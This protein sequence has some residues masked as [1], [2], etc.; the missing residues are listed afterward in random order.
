MS[1]VST[2]Q[3]SASAASAPLDAS[4]GQL[5]LQT[6]TF[7]PPHDRLSPQVR[8]FVDHLVTEAAS[9][10]ER[11]V[12]HLRK[13]R[14][15]LE[16]FLARQHSGVTSFEEALARESSLWQQ[17]V[18]KAV[19]DDK[20]V[21]V[22]HRQVLQLLP[23]LTR[24]HDIKV[25]KPGRPD[26]AVY[27]SSAY[28]REWLP[29]GNCIAEW[30]AAGT[31]QVQATEEDE[32]AASEPQQQTKK[33]K[34]RRTRKNRSKTESGESQQPAAKQPPN[35][36]AICNSDALFFPL[37]RGYRKF[38]GQ[39][40]DG[41]L[42]KRTGKEDEELS[43]FFTKPQAQSRW[44]VSTA[45]ENGEAGH[46]AVLKRGDGQFVFALGS[47][48]THLLAQTLEDVEQAREA[49]RANGSDPFLAAAPIA[50]AVLRMVLALEPDSRALLCEFLWQ[51][52]ATASFE[53][54]CPS[55]QHVQLLDY[56]AE[57]TPV[58]Y[59]L[60][61]PA[62]TPLEGAEICVN[63]VLPYELMRAL[64]VRTVAY[65]VAEF[66]P[67]AFR[68]AL[69]TS[70]RAYQHEGGVHLFLDADAAVIG[71][72]KHKS[73][74]YV[75]LRAIREKSK[76]FCRNLY[77]KKPP[78]GKQTAPTP[79]EVLASAKQA[80]DKRFRAI[81]AFLRI[82]EEVCEAY[83]TLGERF[84]EFLFEQRLFRG[85]AADKEEEE[86]V[87]QVARDVADLFP[88]VWRQ[89]LDHTGLSDAIA[90]R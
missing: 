21:R 11:K 89:F 3:T 33:G 76:A 42:K 81:P 51:T 70:K 27:Q 12:V 77:S 84:L 90:S 82:S 30:R 17:H 87:K 49:Q 2:R 50:T 58:F 13:G 15:Q 78:K 73:V 22:Q 52:R 23:G 67:E 74:W 48:N 24:A 85:A 37:I 18:A 44:V 38:T 41:E 72:Q 68:A 59:G 40:D 54:L 9:K 64:G 47:K 28:A 8:Q 45:K 35:S 10:D 88:V 34:K 65:D 31:E 4:L 61:L 71:M 14:T 1:A 5:Q 7:A 56:L 6:S 66:A 43:K 39:E 79:S 75:C 19:D 55:H 86:Q 53:V 57:D 83:E 80:V 26:D 29:R 16:T 69:E 60:S 36:G 46:L 62:Y 63:P 20:N 32:A 25:G